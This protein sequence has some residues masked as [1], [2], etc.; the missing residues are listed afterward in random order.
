MDERTGK[1]CVLQ[2]ECKPIVCVCCNFCTAHITI[3]K[4]I[5]LPSG[6]EWEAERD[7]RHTE[8]TFDPHCA[9]PTKQQMSDLPDDEYQNNCSI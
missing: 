5:A 9:Q 2:C 1:W 3:K 4:H 7:K 8:A 6:G